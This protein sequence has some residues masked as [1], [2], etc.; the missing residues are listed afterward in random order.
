MTPVTV[1]EI[2]IRAWSIY[3]TAK[4]MAE[5]V[6]SAVHVQCYDPV[7]N[8]AL[9]DA[10]QTIAAAQERLESAKAAYDRKKAA[11]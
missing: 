11:L 4:E 8:A 2:E 9:T 1:E 5:M 6:E 10:L 3:A 7:V